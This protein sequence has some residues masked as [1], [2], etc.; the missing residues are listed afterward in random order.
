MCQSNS[1]LVSPDDEAVDE[2]G[3][4]AT[5][6]GTKCEPRR[7]VV[8]PRP[9]EQ[10]DLVEPGVMALAVTNDA[11]R[12]APGRDTAFF[13]E[14]RRELFWRSEGTAVAS[15]V[16]AAR[17][18]DVIRTETSA[19]AREWETWLR[20]R[21]RRVRKWGRKTDARMARE[22]VMT[23]RSFVVETNF[24]TNLRKEHCPASSS[25]SGE[26]SCRVNP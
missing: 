1:D 23:W 8:T 20:R 19:N 21:R 7:A 26:P 22:R 17:V 18:S 12:L 11:P 6:V 25:P 14:A 4:S 5:A 10:V 24:E 13:G 2:T 15:E 3:G 16:G 9:T